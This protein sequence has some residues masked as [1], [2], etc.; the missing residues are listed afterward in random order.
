ME[1]SFGAPP[2][3]IYSADLYSVSP[4]LYHKAKMVFLWDKQMEQ[5]K[6]LQTYSKDMLE[7]FN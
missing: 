4:K 2:Y 3:L 5:I 6:N 1:R 7:Y